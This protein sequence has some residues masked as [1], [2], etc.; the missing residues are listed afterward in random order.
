MNSKRQVAIEW[1]IF[2]LLLIVCVI[3]TLLNLVA[4]LPTLLSGRMEMR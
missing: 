3:F 1:L 2:I 4:V